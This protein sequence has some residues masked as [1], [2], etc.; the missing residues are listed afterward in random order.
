MERGCPLGRLGGERCIETA[1]VNGRKGAL[2][3]EGQRFVSALSF[4]RQLGKGHALYHEGP[5]SLVSSEDGVWLSRARYRDLSPMTGYSC[6]AY[7]R[8]A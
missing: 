2:Y 4:F 8:A 6:T 3:K 7:G 5:A 1:H